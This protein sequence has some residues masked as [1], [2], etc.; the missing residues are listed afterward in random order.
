MAKEILSRRRN[1]RT[2]P[3]YAVILR[4]M[5]GDVLGRGQ[6][7]NVSDGGIFVMVDLDEVPDV[8]DQFLLE[9]DLPSILADDGSRESQTAHYISRLVRTEHVDE[10]IGLGM[11]L[12]QRLS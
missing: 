10:L 5:T 12:T 2:E 1:E 6:T 8:G 3:R 7:V 4:D 9:V 11:E